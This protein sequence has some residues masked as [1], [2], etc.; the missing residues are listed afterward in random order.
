M[1]SHKA[2]K[3]LTK[4]K[5]MSGF[6]VSL[7]NVKYGTELQEIEVPPHMR[8]RVSFNIDYIDDL[9]GGQGAVPSM[10]ILFT[11][12]PGAGKT[13]QLLQLAN[14][15]AGAGHISLYNSREEALSQIKMTA[16]RLE[17]KNNFYIGDS[18]LVDDEKLDGAV[19]KKWQTH[20][21][22]PGMQRTS[23]IGHAKYLIDNN[24]GKQL[25]LFLDSLQMFN[26]GKYGPGD[27]IEAS[28]IRVIDQLTSFCKQGYKNVHPIMTI[29]G[30]VNK[31]GKF[32]GK[33]KIKHAVD[34]HAHLY[35]EESPKSELWMERIIEMQKNRF[36]CNDKKMILAMN[37]KG[38]S[39]KGEFTFLD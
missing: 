27:V 26:D 35:I 6:N 3:E 5:F 7:E 10:A 19:L 22:R 1:L 32:A 30:Q 36:G 21:S 15:V 11:G 39:K 29:I 2:S 37:S 33:N 16:E 25:F 9:F 31:D 17:L 24:P 14:A 12:T 38:L 8:K 20:W 4:G 34:V 13:T 23:I 28:A 18:E